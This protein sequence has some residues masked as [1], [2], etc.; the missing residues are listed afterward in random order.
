MECINF[1]SQKPATKDYRQSKE[2]VAIFKDQKIGEI[3]KKR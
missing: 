1:I 2:K 3:K